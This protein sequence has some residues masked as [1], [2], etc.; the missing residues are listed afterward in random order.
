M[1][2]FGLVECTKICGVKKIYISQLVDLTGNKT[3]NTQTK[4]VCV[5]NELALKFL[6]FSR[7]DITHDN[8]IA[9]TD[10]LTVKHE[11]A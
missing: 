6:H 7:C 1:K 10:C 3:I 8:A 4:C 5:V 9:Y 11:R 2:R